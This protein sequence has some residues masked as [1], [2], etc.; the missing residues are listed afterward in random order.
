[1]IAGR[2]EQEAPTGFEPV[3]TDLQSVPAESQPANQQGFTQSSPSV[4]AECL[5]LLRRE[6]P[7]LAA[8]VEAWPKLPESIKAGIVAMVKAAGGEV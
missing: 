5:A 2:L 6:S 8:V 1:M 3:V 4:L 7:D